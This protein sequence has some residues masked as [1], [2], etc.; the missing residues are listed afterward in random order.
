[1]RALL[2]SFPH[3]LLPSFPHPINSQHRSASP[4]IVSSGFTPLIVDTGTPDRMIVGEASEGFL[5]TYGIFPILGR[6][7]HADD[8]RDGAPAVALLGHA[9]WQSAFGGDPR[10]LGRDIHPFPLVRAKLARVEAWGRL[11]WDGQGRA[12][13]ALEE[14]K[15]RTIAADPPDLAAVDAYMEALEQYRRWTHGEP[16][17]EATG[18]VGSLS[19]ADLAVKSKR[20][21]LVEVELGARGGQPRRWAVPGTVL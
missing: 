1:M 18:Q 3:S 16:S 19:L 20:Y 5:E 15:Q 21:G 14:A 8:T 17:I 7:I 4:A 10:V 2:P 9:Y 6:G 11:L 12:K 13:R